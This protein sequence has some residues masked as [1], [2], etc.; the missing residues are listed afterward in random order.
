MERFDWGDELPTRTGPRVQLRGM[1][2]ADAPSLLTVFGDPEVMQYWS[3]PPIRDMRDAEEL[4]EDIRGLFASRQLFQWGICPRDGGA[5]FG[6]C[7]LFHLDLAHRRAEVGFAL[8]RGA[9]G[10]GF[11]TEALG[12]LIEFAF[13]ELGLHRLEAD[14]DPENMRSLR[15]LE[16][17]G[18]EREGYLRERWHHL[19]QVR[20]AVFLGLLARDWS[21]SALAR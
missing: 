18:F 12:L 11:A 19:G 9:W 10:Q 15:L 16:R 6:T 8:A 2:L 20:D 4:V 7:T 21:D 5:V 14:A 3:S 17:H 1:T 13:R